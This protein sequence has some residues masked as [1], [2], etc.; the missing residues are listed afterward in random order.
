MLHSLNYS[1]TGMSHLFMPNCHNTHTLAKKK[2]KRKKNLKMNEAEKK[3]NSLHLCWKFKGCQ[4]GPHAMDNWPLAI[5]TPKYGISGKGIHLISSLLY[6]S[7]V[8]LKDHRTL[9]IPLENVACIYPLINQF[10][11][12]KVAGSSLEVYQTLRW[13]LWKR[14][15]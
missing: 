1:V 3:R 7:A 5:P 4:Q 8:F 13:I 9:G 6:S 14:I 10:S 15:V 11:E 2:M 12:R